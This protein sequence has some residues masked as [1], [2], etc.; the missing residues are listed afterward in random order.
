MPIRPYRCIYWSRNRVDGT[1][2]DIDA[3]IRSILVSARRNNRLL[4]VT[5]AL[6]FDRGLFAQLL[7][8]EIRAVEMVFEKIQRDERHGDIQVVIFGPAPERAFPAWPLAFLGRSQ[9]E[10][11]RFAEAGDEA[12][13]SAERPDARR[14]LDIVRTLAV[15]PDT[16]A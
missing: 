9:E 13:A 3:A 7:E 11:R 1:A 2:D 16:D 6:A 12:G 15:D 14:L 8:G 4:G 10:H 5:G